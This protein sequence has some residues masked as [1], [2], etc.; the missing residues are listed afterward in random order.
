MLRCCNISVMM[1]SRGG[2]SE[3]AWS[4]RAAWGGAHV[5]EPWRLPYDD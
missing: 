1:D 4:R 2:G 3:V 5:A